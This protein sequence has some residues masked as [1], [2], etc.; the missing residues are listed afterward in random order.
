MTNPL[1]FNPGMQWVDNRGF[2]TAEAQRLLQQIT[3]SNNGEAA[4]VTVDGQQ[5]L[6]QKTIS[7]D[8][9]TLSDIDTNSLKNLTGDG[10]YVVTAPEPVTGKLALWSNGDLVGGLTPDEV[11][12]VSETIGTNGENAMEAPLLLA[13]YLVADVPNAA[14]YEGGLIY[15]SDEAGGAVI[16]FSD[17]TNWLRVTDRAVIS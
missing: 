9:N 2:L 13:P 1:G 5:T 14:G 17:G 8:Q 15:V 16:A 7:G 4:G 3:A 12:Q 10:N 6:T 11:A